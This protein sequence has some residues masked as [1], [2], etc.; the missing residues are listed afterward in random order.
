MLRPF[1]SFDEVKTL[2]NQRKSKYAHYLGENHDQKFRLV[3]I[4]VLRLGVHFI[5]QPSD[6]TLNFKW[7]NCECK[8]SSTE[9][10]VQCNRLGR[11]SQGN[12]PIRGDNVSPIFQAENEPT[13]FPDD[14]RIRACYRNPKFGSIYGKQL[15][16]THLS[17]VLSTSE[18]CSASQFSFI[19]PPLPRNLASR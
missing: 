9:Y 3:R 13:S 6:G 18:S 12:A 17:T 5:K 19:S 7:R 11:Q 1:S 10:S 4:P 15:A 16:A 2:E 8:A 14:T